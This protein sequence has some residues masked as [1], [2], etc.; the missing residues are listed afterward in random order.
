MSDRN[1]F[2]ILKSKKPVEAQE[3]KEL[4]EEAPY[5]LPVQKLSNSQSISSQYTLMRFDWSNPAEAD[6]NPGTEIVEISE[7]EL[8]DKK[9]KRKKQS[10]LKKKKFT[11]KTAKDTA[12]PKL[13]KKAKAKKKKKKKTKKQKKE[14]L[15]KKD[16]LKILSS[17]LDDFTLWLN[18]LNEEPG[19]NKP[20]NPAEEKSIPEADA[21]LRSKFKK[22]LKKQKTKKNKGHIKL[23]IEDSISDKDNIASLSLAELY[24]RQGYISKAIEMYEKLS[25]KNP[26]KSSFFA[27]QISKLKD[28]I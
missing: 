22:G 2:K 17:E 19:S 10:T 24:E 3:V 1:L 9:N 18:S 21:E 27:A 11:S 16:S 26:E 8:K 13:K 25:L 5:S 4:L 28:K 12:V 14:G 20:E 15:S 6:Q 7:I 23:M